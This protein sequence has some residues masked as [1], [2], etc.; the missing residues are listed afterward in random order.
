MQKFINVILPIPLEK[1]FTYRISES[2]AEVLQAGIR[3]AVPFGKSKIYTGLVYEVHTNPPVIYEAKDIHKILDEQPVV[4]SK[5]LRHWQWLSD[6]YMCTLG[7]VFRSAMPSAFLL[8]SETLIIKNERANINENDL[9]DDEF[10]V[11]EA[12]QYQSML[13]VHEVSAIVDRKNV[14]PILNRLLEKNVILL[15]DEIYERY[16]P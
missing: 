5:Q 9:K 6:Y 1:L 10:L 13:K 15:K 12:L 7:E 2:D 4:N 3:V 11:F 8:E 14:L 16:K